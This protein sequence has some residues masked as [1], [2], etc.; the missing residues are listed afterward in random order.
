MEWV[1]EMRLDGWKSPR[2]RVGFAEVVALVLLARAFCGAVRALAIMGLSLGRG[3]PLKARPFACCVDGVRWYGIVD[4][5]VC[6]R[7]GATVRKN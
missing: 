5:E 3:E 6:D 4:C 7:Q 1:D 2:W